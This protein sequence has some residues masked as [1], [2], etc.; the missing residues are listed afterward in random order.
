MLACLID[1][2]VNNNDL[3]GLEPGLFDKLVSLKEL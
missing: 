3:T 2:S 1:R